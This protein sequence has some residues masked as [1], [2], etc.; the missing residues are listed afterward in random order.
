M[1]GQPAVAGAAGSRHFVQQTA[2]MWADS[3]SWQ[4]PIDGPLEASHRPIYNGLRD[5]Q[6]RMWRD[7]WY[8]LKRP[9]NKG[10]GHSFW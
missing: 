2:A 5:I 4:Y 3:D 7:G 9:L 6:R 8:D 10:H 1:T